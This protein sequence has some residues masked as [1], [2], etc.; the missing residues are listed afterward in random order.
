MYELKVRY[1]E[2]L[3]GEGCLNEVLF[4]KPEWDED[5]GHMIADHGEERLVAMVPSDVISRQWEGD[6]FCLEA[7]AS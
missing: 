2:M 1:L 6:P 7:L 5:D 4:D 3:Q